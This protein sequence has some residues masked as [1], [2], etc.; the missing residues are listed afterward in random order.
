MVTYTSGTEDTSGSPHH[1]YVSGV[2]YCSGNVPY[3]LL[4]NQTLPGEHQFRIVL[5]TPAI[6]PSTAVARVGEAFP[7][8]ELQKK[9]IKNSSS[10]TKGKK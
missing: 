7:V 6:P 9:K 3:H 2:W 5:L 8:V 1:L 4:L 10:R